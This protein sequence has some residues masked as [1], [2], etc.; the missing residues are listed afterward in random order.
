MEVS[1]EEGFGGNRFGKEGSGGK[2]GFG[3]EGFGTGSC[4]GG[5]G[6]H[7]TDR[8]GKRGFVTEGSR[9]EGCGDREGFCTEGVGKGFGT[10]FRAEHLGNEALA[11]ALRILQDKLRR[12]DE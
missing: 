8:S 6:G 9:N 11:E 1:G 7:G 5:F 3:N 10:G 4:T 2:E 12:V